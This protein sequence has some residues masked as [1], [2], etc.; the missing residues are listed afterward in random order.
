MHYTTRKFWKCYDTLP[1]NVQDTANQCYSLL[2][3][4]PSH[5]SLHLKKILNSVDPDI[6]IY[7]TLDQSKQLDKLGEFVIENIR[8][9][10]LDQFYGLI[11]YPPAPFASHKL[12]C[13]LH[14]N[15]TP[16]QLSIMREV[17]T[18]CIDN[19]IGE[20]LYNLDRSNYQSDISI[21]VDDRTVS[22]DGN[23]L[24]MELHID[25]GWI[26]RFS[27]HYNENEELLH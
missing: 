1:E 10:N 2:K 7:M 27:K 22:E 6:F 8:D 9:A 3:V 13:K 19:T 25:E 14:D 18:Y 11:S 12:R 4:E 17:I 26:A 23:C 5:P 15:F 24:R 21:C 16:E 20:L